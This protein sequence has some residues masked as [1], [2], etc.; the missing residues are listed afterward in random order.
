MA[1]AGRVVAAESCGSVNKGRWLQAQALGNQRRPP[2]G[3]AVVLES[4]LKEV[5][6]GDSSQRARHQQRHRGWGARKVQGSE[7]PRVGQERRMLPSDSTN[8]Y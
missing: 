8:T 7:V 5:G 4:H 6:A 2:G 1:T 3:K